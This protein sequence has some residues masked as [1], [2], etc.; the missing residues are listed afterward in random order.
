[1]IEETIFSNKETANSKQLAVLKQHFPQC[2]DKDGKFITDRLVEVV[3]ADGVELSKESY[4]LNWVGKSYARLLTNLPPK[5][6]LKEDVEH[7]SLDQNKD[8]QNLLIKGDNLEVL[9]H[10]VR[11][12]SEE[13]KLIYIDPPYN[14]GSG[15]FVYNDDRSF[16]PD[17]LAELANI[18]L[19]DAERIL[20]FN[21]KGASSHSAWLTFMYP[22]L[23]LAKELLADDGAIFISID[24]N[25]Q[26][27]LKMICDEVFGESNFIS[28]VIWQKKYSPQNDAKWLS[29]NHDFILCYAKNKEVWRPNLLPRNDK[30][31]DAYK[32][33]DNDPRGV[34]KAVD[35][36]RKANLEHT[37]YDITT[38]SGRVVSPPNGRSWA[39]SPEGFQ[40]LIDDNRI[41][42]GSDG[43]NVPAVK[44]FLHEVKDGITPLTIWTYQE[45]GH[46]Q[47]AKQELKKLF[48]DNKDIFETPKPLSL[49]ERVIQIGA[50]SDSI[51][52]DFFAGSGTT[53]HQVLKQNVIDNGSRKFIAVQ[54]PEEFKSRE[55]EP[56]WK[57]IFDITKARIIK[58]AEHLK[59]E[60]P[61]YKGDLGFKIFETVDD[62]RNVDEDSNE[63]LSNI[64]MFDD[65]LLTDEQ[66]N[67]LLTTWCVY[68]G[69]ELIEPVKDVDLNGYTAHLC[70]NRLYMLASEFSSSALTALLSKLDTDRNFAPNKVIIYGS[71]FDSAKQREINDA[72]NSYSNKKS[73]E[74]DLVVRN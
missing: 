70:E 73:I 12:Y 32:N 35:F 21:D 55:K 52:V 49:L 20:S 18:S 45:V 48:P 54:L 68:D 1:M 4:S 19:D 65:V 36:S 41:W 60:N 13:V 40:E 39:K 11:A 53:A 59:S 37:T 62:F 2:F 10:M 30:Q 9:N 16:T 24:D 71:N 28:N 56:V 27:P 66:Y 44:K 15:D 47:T 8:S 29:D 33:P 57:S 6:L 72:L 64:T 17:Q 46:N 50:D 25:E 42:F 14:T 63:P 31:N 43:N 69:S 22:R 74:L 38:P 51:I 7:N 26:A 3:K 58:A 34:W 67:I 5:T 23:Y 61:E